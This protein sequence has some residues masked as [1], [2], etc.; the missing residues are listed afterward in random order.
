MNLSD[1]ILDILALKQ[2]IKIK[3]MSVQV[4]NNKLIVVVEL[5]DDYQAKMLHR[6]IT[7]HKEKV[8][9]MIKR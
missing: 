5:E 8:E 6:V 7:K 3:D 2:F 1:V 4:E 9:S